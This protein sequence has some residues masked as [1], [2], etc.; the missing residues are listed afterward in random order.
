MKDD[1][2]L[3]QLI[4]ESKK[5]IS[6]LVQNITK[7]HITVD[8]TLNGSFESIIKLRTNEDKLIIAVKRAITA[9]H[10]LSQSEQEIQKQLEKFK[11]ERFNKRINL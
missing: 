6:G 8:S 4:N 10:A 1:K 5:R 11:N 3:C 7:L 9:E 2:N